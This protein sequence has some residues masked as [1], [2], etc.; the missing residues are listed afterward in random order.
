MDYHWPGNV[1]ELENII[2]RALV[3]GSGKE[4]GVG[5]LPFSRGDGT[6]SDSPKS[7]KAMEKAHIMRILEQTAWNISKAAREMDIDRQ[8][9]YNKMKKYAIVKR[10]S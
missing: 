8:T 7:L 1:R 5:D 3:I 4:I 10:E 6:V 9:L 2:E